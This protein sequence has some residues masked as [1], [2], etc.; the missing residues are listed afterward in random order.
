MKL[1][2]RWRRRSKARS[3]KDG[4][5]RQRNGDGIPRGSPVPPPV[6]KVKPRTSQIDPG[7]G[8]PIGPALDTGEIIGLSFS[9]TKRPVHIQAGTGDGKTLLQSHLVERFI[10]KTDAAVLY[11][12]F[13]EDQAAAN[14]VRDAAKKHGRTFRL[15][16]TVPEHASS[17]FNAFKP[18]WPLRKETAVLA[19]NYL[20]TSLSLDHGEGIKAFWGK[21]NN[22]TLLRSMNAL[23]DAGVTHPDFRILATQLDKTARGVR[24]QDAVEALLQIEQL[25]P[26]DILCAGDPENEIDY[27]RVLENRE[28]VYL[29]LGTLLNPPAR[30]IG[31]LAVWAAMLAAIK[32]KRQGLPHRRFVL[33]I[34]EY[35]SVAA[36]KAFSDLVTLSRKF[37]VSLI[38][39]NQSTQQLRQSDTE[40]VVFDNAPT[41]FWM[42]PLGYDI[43]TIRGLSK[44]VW[45]KRKGKTT[46]GL[47]VANQVSEYKDPKTERNDVLGAAFSP[48]EG[49]AIKL[50][51]GYQEPTR[52]RFEPPWTIEQW[53]ELENRPLPMRKELE[54]QSR[55]VQPQIHLPAN[56]KEQ[57]R[58]RAVLRR[59]LEEKKEME[60]WKPA[61]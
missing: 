22:I 14:Y 7:P 52:F 39:A 38:L 46:H 53:T 36:A 57:R 3:D 51:E 20:A 8:I 54:A 19:T 26:Y 16:S 58:R 12:D 61:S 21:V 25:A 50:G 1:F 9:Q 35:A 30:S 32:R 59:I 29:L 11:V 55:H 13:G 6:I 18:V 10:A 44:E 56:T 43:E 41:K 60:S 42:S 5:G 15:L 34:D 27:D 49:Y 17:T 45:K 23:I 2:G 37:F 33:N 48:L 47:S 28:V 40:Q 31:A 24:K 4:N